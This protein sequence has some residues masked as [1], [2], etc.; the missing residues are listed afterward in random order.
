MFASSQPSRRCWCWRSARSRSWARL[1]CWVAHRQRAW[2]GGGLVGAPQPAKH[3]GGLAA[4]GLLL[5]GQGSLGL[6]AV[7]AGPG[8]LTAAVA[9][10][11]VELAAEPVPLGPQLRRRQLSQVQAAR[12]VDG[13]G[14]PTSP[15]Q[16]L[17]QLQIPIGLLPF[18]QVQ[19][20]GVLG[21]GADHRVQAG[22]LA[23][24]GQLHIQ[25]VH[26]LGAGEPD[27]GPPPSQPWARCPVVA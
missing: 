5:G 17:G 2:Y 26:V 6:L 14:L 21:L 8:K 23:G 1:T 7:G 15:G 12:G 24:P 11:F 22:V 19:V 9:G 18:R 4:A 13:Q 25:P 27:Q 16:G 20:P 3:A 10:G